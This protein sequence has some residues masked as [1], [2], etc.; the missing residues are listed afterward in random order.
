MTAPARS[1]RPDRVGWL[2]ATVLLGGAL[3]PTLTQ[4]PNRLLT[5]VGL[6]L[7]D[8]IGRASSP[9]P[10]LG[11]AVAAVLVILLLAL[12]LPVRS[13]SE[14]SLSGTAGGRDA[15]RLIA[16]PLLATLLLAL[17]GREAQARAGDED[18]LVRVALGGGF[19]LL[20]LGC[21]L[22]FMESRRRLALHWRWSVPL[23][24][25][26]ALLA[27]IPAG[28]LLATGHLDALSLLREYANDPD[29]FHEA[30]LRHVELVGLSLLPAIPMGVLLG[31]A[32]FHGPRWRSGLFAVLNVVQTVPSI[33]LYGLLIAPLAWLGRQ[34]PSSGIAGVGLAPALL[35]L[36]LY[37]L[38]PLA[39]GTYAGL[40]QVPPHTREAARGIGLSAAQVFWQ[41]E[42]PLALPVFIGGVRITAVQSV[43]LAAVAAL[44]GAGGLGAILFQGLSASAIDQVLLGVLPLVALA[45]MMDAAFRLAIAGLTRNTHDPH[46]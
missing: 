40:Q 5:G 17:A 46:H 20:V 13:V 42:L 36:T 26:L 24:T 41:I 21:T 18:A 31:L 30:V 14:P 3:L 12:V 44:I 32:A 16:A 6:D 10:L 8:L 19:W 33:A 39:R 38:L 11:G 45:M 7:T 27:L 37:A 9:D 34:W 15:L 28:V 22:V 4:A 2:L 43:G 25:G 1:F 23:Q 29:V 35:A